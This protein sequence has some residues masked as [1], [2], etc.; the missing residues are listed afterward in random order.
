MLQ[1]TDVNQ[2]AFTIVISPVASNGVT[3]LQL[4]A[5]C[6]FTSS[7]DIKKDIYEY[8]QIFVSIALFMVRLRDGG[9][10]F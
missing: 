7:N 8:P 2:F 4:I 6:V 9:R 10:I 5:S 1:L 3:N